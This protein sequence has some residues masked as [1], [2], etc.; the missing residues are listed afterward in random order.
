LGQIRIKNFELYVIAFNNII[1]KIQFL[2]VA[3][4]GVKFPSNDIEWNRP[5]NFKIFNKE[6]ILFLFVDNLFQFNFINFY[7][8][9]IIR[10]SVFAHMDV[11]SII[12]EIK[13]SVMKDELTIIGN[14]GSVYKVKIEFENNK[15]N[16]LKSEDIQTNNLFIIDSKY[17]SPSLVKEWTASTSIIIRTP[18]FYDFISIPFDEPLQIYNIITKSFNLKNDLIYFSIL[19]N[20]QLVINYKK[21][22]I[23][24]NILNEKKLLPM[25]ISMGEDFIFDTYNRYNDFDITFIKSTNFIHYFLISI[26]DKCFVIIFNENE[27]TFKLKT[28][29]EFL[30]IDKKGIINE[31]SVT[32][33]G[34][35]VF[36]IGNNKL[37]MFDTKQEFGEMSEIYIDQYEIDKL[38]KKNIVNKQ[39]TMIYLKNIFKYKTPIDTMILKS[40]SLSKKLFYYLNKKKIITLGY[41]LTPDGR[42]KK[43]GEELQL[44]IIKEMNIDENLFSNKIKI[45]KSHLDKIYNLFYYLI[46]EE[47]MYLKESS[48]NK[49]LEIIKNVI[50]QLKSKEVPN[51]N[52]LFNKMLFGFEP[53]YY[54]FVETMFFY[55]LLH[56][57]TENKIINE[58]YKIILLSQI[59]TIGKGLHL[60][61]YSVLFK[62][63]NNVDIIKD[64]YLNEVFLFNEEMYENLVRLF[65]KI[66]IIPKRFNFYRWYRNTCSKLA[67]N[68]LNNNL[69]LQTEKETILAHK[70][71]LIMNSDYF[72]ALF[73]NDFIE[74]E[75]KTIKISGAWFYLKG[76]LSFYKTSIYVNG[77]NFVSKISDIENVSINLSF[78]IINIFDQQLEFDLIK[79][80]LY[81]IKSLLINNHHEDQFEILMKG[82]EKY[83]TLENEKYWVNIFKLLNR[84]GIIKKQ[85]KTDLS[86]YFMDSVS[87]ILMES[88][89]FL[90]NE[91]YYEAI[92]NITRSSLLLDLLKEFV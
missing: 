19:S 80:I 86:H 42:D 62:V 57:L 65:L 23:I 61:I 60:L 52:T 51:L 33:F 83:I 22:L 64:L 48:Q 79:K 8:E 12:T 18:N 76:F 4:E 36:F 71:I 24:S 82:V 46:P 81:Q 91:K 47:N 34:D 6:I 27:L 85:I 25:L 74:H 84:M 41:M 28:I 68:E 67:V 35:N 16:I 14:L 40:D 59:M 20:Y 56:V 13:I 9:K 70:E 43:I 45:T 78:H 37:R 50:K 38:I 30:H 87:E 58:S 11:Q 63:F 92:Q 69:I 77:S 88:E 29:K 54:N 73:Q 75:S 26:S 39:N 10:F 17:Q 32:F 72:F 7:I 89:T 66:T 15:I 2:G 21:R 90:N 3:V 49:E 53:N 55:R 5:N 44:K 1:Q 31:Q